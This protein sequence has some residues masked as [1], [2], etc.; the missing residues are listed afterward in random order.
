M[1]P[2]LFVLSVEGIAKAFKRNGNIRGIHVNQ[3]EIKISQY[4]DDTSL[5][6][7]GS[8]ASLSAALNT[9]DDFGEASGLKLNSKKT[10]AIWIGANSGKTE[11]LFPERN[12][13]WQTKK[14][15]SL[16]AQ[17]V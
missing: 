13:R 9:L 3:E 12:F 15:K 4:A 6:S 16:G 2:F 14:V 11:I 1:S 5:I 7:N 10:E 8:Q 17:A